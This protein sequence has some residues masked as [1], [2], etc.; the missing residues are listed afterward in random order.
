[1]ILLSLLSSLI[2]SIIPQTPARGIVV[3]GGP[4]NTLNTGLVAFYEMD[5]ASGS[6]IQDSFGTNHF[7]TQPGSV[8]STTG[9]AVNS[10]GSRTV[11]ASNRY[12]T[13]TNENMLF[14]SSM[15]VAG[16][17]KIGSTGASQILMSVWN[18]TSNQRCWMVRVSTTDTLQL[19]LSF[20]GSTF[21][22]FAHTTTL[23]TATNYFFCIRRNDADVKINV[24]PIG[25]SL[26]SDISP[27]GGSSGALF[28]SSALTTVFA[29]VT[30]TSP[31]SPM[32]AGGTLDQVGLWN[33]AISDDDQ[34]A[35]YDNGDSLPLADFE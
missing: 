34:A 5:G 18:T 27:G 15:T 2:I 35:L 9:L 3:S 17:L 8:G 7:E 25:D 29:G 19:L 22:T 33:I 14:G 10:V 21:T 30:G 1:M 24:T 26:T 6:L 12:Q 31:S 20:D 13:R 32:L 11:A 4:A 16:L 28:A 23:S